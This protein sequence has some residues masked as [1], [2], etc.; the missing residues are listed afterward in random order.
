MIAQ[1]PKFSAGTLSAAAGSPLLSL[2]DS[3]RLARTLR[4]RTHAER[5]L[6]R[7]TLQKVYAEWHGQWALP[8]AATGAR[9]D[10]RLVDVVST[11]TLSDERAQELTK[12]VLFGERATRP[13]LS[14][15][16]ADGWAMSEALGDEAWAAWL[17][18]LAPFLEGTGRAAVSPGQ[19]DPWSG[20][21]HIAFPWAGGE[22]VLQLGALQVDRLLGRRRAAPVPNPQAVSK[23]AGLT[24][25]SSAMGGHALTV[26]VELGSLTLNLGQLRSL[27]VGDIVTLDHALDTPAAMYLVPLEDEGTSGRA[28]TAPLCA[29]WLGQTSGQMAVELLPLS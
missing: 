6:V 16:P 12:V 18:A 8:S 3:R 24:P 7:E 20:A 27:S 9:Q 21:L 25:L 1:S 5:E 19:V 17:A 26:R 11:T 13:D 2:E 23:L 22:W 14:P 15:R 4:S 28:S 29:S 10:V